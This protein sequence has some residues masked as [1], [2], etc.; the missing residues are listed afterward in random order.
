MRIDN[1]EYEVLIPEFNRRQLQQQMGNQVSLHTIEYIEGNPMQG[2]MSPRLIG[3]LSEVER[4]FFELFCSVDGVGVRKALRA[5]MRP[6]KEVATAIEEQ[7]AKFLSSLPGIGPAMSERIIAKLRRQVP[8]FALMVAQR[9]AGGSEVESDVV[10]ETFEVLRKLGHSESEA[11]RLL[12]TA[13][14]AK[15][16]YAD[17]QALLQAIY[18]Q[19]QK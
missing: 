11:R 17:V 8:K 19:S 1:F 15:K 2:R 18:Q 4:E 9:E 6:V 7:D 14:A 12:D 10:S 3:F 13:L 5:M 16:K